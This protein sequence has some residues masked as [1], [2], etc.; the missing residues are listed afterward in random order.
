MAPDE[1]QSRL[2]K[3]RISPN[4]GEG[5]ALAFAHGFNIHFGQIE[6]R[7]DLDVIMIAP[8]GPGHLVPDRRLSGRHR[9][10]PGHRLGVRLGE[11]RGTRWYH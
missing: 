2:Y 5:A 4:I 10:G 11:W 6:P 1:H 8:K 3:E 7:E 9:P